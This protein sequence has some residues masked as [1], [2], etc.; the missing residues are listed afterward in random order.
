MPL[1]ILPGN[2]VNI[3]NIFNSKQ[4]VPVLR[5]APVLMVIKYGIS[6]EIAGGQWR[7]LMDYLL[8]LIEKFYLFS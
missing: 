6:Y 5:Q 7:G 2:N 8:I 3:K 1:G 4:R